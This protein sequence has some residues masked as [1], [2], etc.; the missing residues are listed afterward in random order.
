M[1]TLDRGGPVG[2]RRQGLPVRFCVSDSVVR[3]DSGVRKC[4]CSSSQYGRMAVKTGS[5]E[6]LVAALFASHIVPRSTISPDTWGSLPAV[7]HRGWTLRDNALSP[8][9]PYQE[10]KTPV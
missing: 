9:P 7:S 4:Y 5:P 1:K 2:I 3:Q 8:V 10:T 6:A